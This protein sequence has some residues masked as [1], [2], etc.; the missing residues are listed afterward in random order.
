MTSSPIEAS[1]LHN[2]LG[3]EKM[4]VMRSLVAFCFGVLAFTGVVW[5][6][7]SPVLDEL[8]EAERAI[9][10]A[11]KAHR[12]LQG[13]IERLE[14]KPKDAAGQR[15]V[16]PTDRSLLETSF[17]SAKGAQVAARIAYSKAVVQANR[18]RNISARILMLAARYSALERAFYGL[19]KRTDALRRSISSPPTP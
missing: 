11:G 12:I 7:Q 10:L 17:Q 14:K 2:P 5:A 4:P 8:H 3:G 19:N 15:A 16:V 13:Q 18:R 6:E 9:N 1:N